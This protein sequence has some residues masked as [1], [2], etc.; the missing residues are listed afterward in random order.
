MAIRRDKRQGYSYQTKIDLYK[1]CI[2]TRFSITVTA[3]M[4][5]S[6]EKKKLNIKLHNKQQNIIII[7][8]F[9]LQLC[10][11]QHIYRIFK[12][13]VVSYHIKL[14][15]FTLDQFIPISS[16]TFATWNKSKI[17]SIQIILSQ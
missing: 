9:Y 17:I 7:C 12:T 4:P 6:D 2:I 8:K 5:G 10:Y 15:I 11:K 14:H 16:M 3:I 1:L 13:P